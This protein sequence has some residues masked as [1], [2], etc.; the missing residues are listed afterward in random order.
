MHCRLV[1][2]CGNST[3]QDFRHHPLGGGQIP[4]VCG[5]NPINEVTAWASWDTPKRSHFVKTNLAIGTVVK[6]VLRGQECVAY[7][8]LAGVVSENGK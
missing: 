4:L 5:Y 6:H 8:S 7:G 1:D 3:N 2:V